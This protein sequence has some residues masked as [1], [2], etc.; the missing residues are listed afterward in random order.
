MLPGSP[1]RGRRRRLINGVRGVFSDNTYAA[2]QESSSSDVR[3]EIISSSRTRNTAVFQPTFNAS[4]EHG[5]RIDVAKDGS[6]ITAV[7][8]AKTTTTT[9][10]RRKNS[11]N[12]SAVRRTSPILYSDVREVSPNYSLNQSLSKHDLMDA[13]GNQRQK[14]KRVRPPR[15]TS[16]NVDI[17]T[18]LPDQHNNIDVIKS[19]IRFARDQLRKAKGLTPTFSGSPNNIRQQSQIQSTERGGRVAWDLDEQ[20]QST[21][22]QK[23]SNN[24]DEISFGSFPILSNHSFG[25]DLAETINK[26]AH[27]GL[28]VRQEDDSLPFETILQRRM[29]EIQSRQAELKKTMTHKDMMRGTLISAFDQNLEKNRKKLT[30]LQEELET[31]R[32]HLS[33]EDHE[34]DKNFTLLRRKMEQSAANNQAAD[35]MP[36]FDLESVGDPSITADTDSVADLFNRANKARQKTMKGMDPPER[37][38]PSPP[39]DE[40]SF[41]D[42]RQSSNLETKDPKGSK[43]SVNGESHQRQGNFLKKPTPLHPAASA[44]SSSNSSN[45]REKQIKQ[46]QNVRVPPP[47]SRKSPAKMVHFNLPHES[48]ELKYDLNDSI[49][50]PS[51]SF[52]QT[53]NDSDDLSWQ[54]GH[55][56]VDEYDEKSEPMYGTNFKHI[57]KYKC[58][59]YER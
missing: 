46:T 50:N 42:F 14:M 32:W 20:T 15:K 1:R 44:G 10:T 5:Y 57:I 23:H 30:S 33:L 54:G 52:V 27:T 41:G 47:R 56:D 16:N 37:P 9:G 7:P 58:F 29:E 39:T 59:L 11:N 21:N 53:R 51:S 26:N 8:I 49:D 45:L 40:E 38:S 34:R 43:V 55:F 28:N 12:T 18:P 35:P 6:M 2:V 13:R 19:P 36:S 3:K 17:A 22:L 4:E 25:K 31:I 24:I 48:A